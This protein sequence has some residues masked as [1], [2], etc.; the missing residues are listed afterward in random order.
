MACGAALFG[1]SL[2]TKK[3]IRLID[4]LPM[5]IGGCLLDGSFKVFFPSNTP[6]PAEHKIGVTTTYDEQDIIEVNLYQ[7]ESQWVA[8][9]EYLGSFHVSEFP[10]ASKGQ[11]RIAV[12]MRLDQESIMR[13]AATD[14]V[15]NKSVDVKMV[16]REPDQ[17]QHRPSP[18]TPPPPVEQPEPEEDDAQPRFSRPPTKKGV[19]PGLREFIR[20]I[21]DHSDS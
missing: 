9:N 15:T 11:I 2:G 16:A 5:S 6:L 18:P 1:H 13:V 21:R 14:L 20:R 19:F 4:V 3:S 10:K 8:E 12:T 7:G 17:L